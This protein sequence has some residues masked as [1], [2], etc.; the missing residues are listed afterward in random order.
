[1]SGETIC[2]KRTWPVYLP[3]KKDKGIKRSSSINL[4]VWVGVRIANYFPAGPNCL[5]AGYYFGTVKRIC[6]NHVKIEYDD[7]DDENMHKKTFLRLMKS[8]VRRKIFNGDY[9]LPKLNIVQEDEA[10]SIECFKEAQERIKEVQERISD[11]IIIDS[12]LELPT[13][14]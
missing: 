2:I 1:M 3:K 11:Q 4:P 5:H 9:S 13:R 8:V 12:L 7:G 6:K 14:V 10:R